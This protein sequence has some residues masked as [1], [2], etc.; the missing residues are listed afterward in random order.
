MSR[1][2]TCLCASAPN[3]RVLTGV[4]LRKVIPLAV[5]GGVLVA[6]GGVFG[7]S[8]AMA[9]DVEVSQDGVPMK[10]R[11]WSGTVGEAL[12][13]QNIQV[14]ER[15][16]VAPALGEKLADGQQISV[17]YGRQLNLS[18]DGEKSSMW[19]TAT[20]VEQALAEMSIRDES[21][22][23]T[24]RSAA[25]GREGLDLNIETAKQITVVVA[26]E[27]RT[28]I[29]PAET[30]GQALAEAQ[31]EYAPTDRLDPGVDTPIT[32]G[33]TVAVN[34][35][36]TKE[37]TREIEIPFKTV[38]KESSSLPKGTEKVDTKGVPGKTIEVW[39]ERF[40][41]GKSIE[42][43]MTSSRV[44]KQPV[45]EVVLV[46]TGSTATPTPKS[47]TPSKSPSKAP[48]TS[49]SRPSSPPSKSAGTNAG[50]GSGSGSTGGSPAVGSTCQASMYDEGQM[51]A[52]GEVFN[53]NALTAAH[54]TLPFGTMVKV[55]NPS[56]GKTVTVRINDR[57]PYI[58][59]R[60]LDLS[61]AAFSAIGNVSQG[62]MTVVY[63]PL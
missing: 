6:S 2:D 33:L 7:V 12:Q 10:V 49:S 26:G 24:S 62:V 46:G 39:T 1:G 52:N 36:D 19:T 47:T 22:L 45:D 59:G 48:T 23:S 21:K 41:N 37:T 8:Q 5:A 29:T 27:S 34:K 40:E 9:K 35:V 11:T 57:G 17:R 61:K 13:A 3:S 54:K 56:N 14:G 42:N 50:S 53:T 4:E 60:C 15:D 25:I 30:V 58:A 43:K 51:T 16:Q 32:E 20:T 44:D 31:I 28:V 18:V 38:R 63:Q 55:T